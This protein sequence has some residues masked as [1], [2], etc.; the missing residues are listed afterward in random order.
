MSGNHGKF[1][2]FFCVFLLLTLVAMLAVASLVIQIFTWR[3]MVGGEGPG[4][5]MPGR[6]WGPREEPELAKQIR[7]NLAMFQIDNGAGPPIKHVLENTRFG[8]SGEDR[9]WTMGILISLQSN[10]IYYDIATGKYGGYFIDVT[11]AVCKAAG[12]NC[13]F[14]FVDNNPD[15]PPMCWD[16]SEEFGARGGVGLHS[17]WIDAC[18]GFSPTYTRALA[19]DFTDSV[20][21]QTQAFFYVLQGNPNNFNWR[22]LRGKRIGFLT[23][24]YTDP[25][26]VARNGDRIQGAKLDSSQIVYYTQPDDIYDALQ[27]REI[28]AGF[29]SNELEDLSNRLEVASDKITTCT[30][31]ADALMTRKDNPISEW[32]NPALRTV[33]RSRE[34]REICK[35]V[36]DYYNTFLPG[37][38][39]EFVCLG[40]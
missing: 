27:R 30:I 28:D 31:A 36:D 22:D 25:D 12:K 17:Q 11:H 32:F 23:I 10:L 8:Y 38:S 7:E 35:D 6:R 14:V 15:N 1:G 33:L 20:V 21:P 2:G 9:V 18:V 40:Y 39:S 3:K 5:G 29:F 37:R 34:Y 24:W 26:C 13:R 4:M 16:T 19:F